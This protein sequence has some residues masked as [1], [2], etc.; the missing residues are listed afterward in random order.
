ML[1]GDA[2]GGHISSTRLFFPPG[3]TPGGGFRAV[4]KTLRAVGKVKL[5]FKTSNERGSSVNKTR[6][7]LIPFTPLPMRKFFPY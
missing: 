1:N 5:Q 7:H 2:V 3:D 4:E 6:F